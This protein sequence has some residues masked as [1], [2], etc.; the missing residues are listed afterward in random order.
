MIDH[1][2]TKSIAIWAVT[3]QGAQLART[4]A[5]RLPGADLFFSVN[6]EEKDFP[7][8]TFEILSEALPRFFNEYQGHVF[9]M[10]TGIVV[11]MIAPLIRHKTLDPAVVVVDETGRHAISLL[12]GHIGGANRLARNIAAL[13]GADPVITTATDLNRVPAVDVLAV[14]KNLFIEN[15]AAV[16][17]VNMALL[18]GRKIFLHD[19]FGLL[20]DTM[21]GSILVTG[22]AE[23]MSKLFFEKTPGV[24]IDDVRVDL[25]AGVLVL[26]PRSLAAGVGCNRNTSPE[27]IKSFLFAIFD[28]F[29][30]SLYSLYSLATIDIKADEPGILALSKE[31]ELPITFYDQEELNRVKNIATPSDMVEKHTGVKSVCEAA[32]I[33]SSNSG[34]LIVPK[35]STRNVTVAIARKSFTS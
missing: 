3:P 14:E 32:A 22:D 27:E 20:I 9:I 5:A 26:R 28:R 31:L 12:S 23:S 33:L 34:K 15:P 6:L 1:Q 7:G 35:Q 30:L 24:F 19:P 13:I 10:A 8:R 4:I 29:G 17:G 11:R 21:P 2:R 25:P 18:T 16:K